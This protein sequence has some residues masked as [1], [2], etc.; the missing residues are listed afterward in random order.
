M[1]QLLEQLD[2][3]L[4]ELYRKALDAD[5]VLEIGRAHV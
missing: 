5:A 4:K 1:D 3:N 2:Q